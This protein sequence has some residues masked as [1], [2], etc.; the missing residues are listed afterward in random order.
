M[1]TDKDWKEIHN[2]KA[3]I[4][5]AK[6]DLARGGF[7]RTLEILEFILTE[8]AKVMFRK[9]GKPKTTIEL[10]GSIFQVI[11]FIKSVIRMINGATIKEKPV[12]RI[13]GNTVKAIDD[14]VER[15]RR[16]NKSL[17]DPKSPKGK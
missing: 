11:G 5:H 17:S 4:A 2:T 6:D 15:S 10:I 16:V 9:D 14:A 12:N 7:L 1:L 8:A 13:P 3:I